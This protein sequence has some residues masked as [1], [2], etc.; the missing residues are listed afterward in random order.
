MVISWD[1]ERLK[2]FGFVLVFPLLHQCGAKCQLFFHLRFFF[3]QELLA[4]VNCLEEKITSLYEKPS[5]VKDH[6]KCTTVHL[7]II[8]FATK[9]H[10]FS[11]LRLY[12]CLG[13][14]ISLPLNWGRGRRESASTG[15][16]IVFYSKYSL[17]LK[18]GKQRL[19]NQ[20]ISKAPFWEVFFWA[21]WFL[22]SSCLWLFK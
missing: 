13:N 17:F 2:I 3:S 22:M 14:E 15:M 11:W 20:N 1:A 10:N 6:I 8:W 21:F 18:K 5:L 16:K 19:V 4:F 7:K 9:L 12:L